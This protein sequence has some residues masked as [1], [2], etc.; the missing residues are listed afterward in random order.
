MANPII[1]ESLK[2]FLPI[3]LIR[4][5]SEFVTVIHPIVDNFYLNIVNKYY[6]I[7]V[8]R[9]IGVKIFPGAISQYWKK[10]VQYDGGIV[11]FIHIKKLN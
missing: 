3:E 10:T 1:S 5:V 9:D 7:A 11:K 2:Y 8:F 4:M 6:N